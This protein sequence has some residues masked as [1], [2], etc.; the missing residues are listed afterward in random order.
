[1]P[2]YARPTNKR[3]RTAKWS[4]RQDGAS[5]DYASGPPIVIRPDLVLAVQLV[6][7]G[8]ASS[9][10]E[11][12]ITEPPVIK[13]NDKT[14]AAAQVRCTTVAE[15]RAALGHICTVVGVYKLEEFTNKKGVPFRNWPVVV[16]SGGSETVALESLW[17]ES[18]MPTAAE[19]AR[20]LDHT[21]EVTGKLHSQPPSDQHIANMGQLT[22]SPVE[23]IRLVR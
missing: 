6:I 23:S 8:C 13:P 15:V 21:V 19:I 17:D 12:P 9:T 5:S 18:K 2:R 22:I 14:S 16:L 20:W 10:L 3:E 1:M 11:S 7:T 4:Q